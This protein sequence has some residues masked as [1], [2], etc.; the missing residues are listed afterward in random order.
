M[1]NNLVLSTIFV[2]FYAVSVVDSISWHVKNPLKSE[3]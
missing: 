2:D 3:N 1:W